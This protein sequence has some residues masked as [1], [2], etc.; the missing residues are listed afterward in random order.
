M[1]DR[2]LIKVNLLS[3][4]DSVNYNALFWYALQTL[5]DLAKS[6]RVLSNNTAIIILKGAFT[7]C[8]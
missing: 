1:I 2:D 3:I 8:T 7:I 6:L 5:R 4:T